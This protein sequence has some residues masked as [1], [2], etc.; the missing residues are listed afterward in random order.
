M[1]ELGAGSKSM[2]MHAQTQ[3]DYSPPCVAALGTQAQQG[4]AAGLNP[5]SVYSPE[6]MLFDC[7]S[8]LFKRAHT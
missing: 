5:Q 2:A 1:G 8:A 7:T 3:R 4:I 6:E